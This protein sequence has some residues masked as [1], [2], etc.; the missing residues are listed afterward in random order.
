MP[1]A[2]GNT[3]TRSV[4]V[5][6]RSRSFGASASRD[7]PFA[8]RDRGVRFHPRNLD[9]SSQARTSPNGAI[10][11]KRRELSGNLVARALS[12]HRHSLPK[13]DRDPSLMS[14]D[15][16]L[17]SP[18][19]RNNVMIAWRTTRSAAMISYRERAVSSERFRCAHTSP[20]GRSRGGGHFHNR[21]FNMIRERRRE[22][23]S[24]SRSSR[25]N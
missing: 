5:F 25:A 19:F 14:K 10:R 22:G 23:R 17:L 16:V 9:H 12:G 8:L 1:M 6:P 15:Q 7:L 24:L 4:S 2:R 3:P 13:I 20:E 21:E 11:L 18:S